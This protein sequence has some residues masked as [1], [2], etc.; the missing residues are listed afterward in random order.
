MAS[1]TYLYYVRRPIPSANVAV[2]PIP[3]WREDH[4]QP[5]ELAQRSRRS[6]LQVPS[7]AL[8]ECSGMNGYN[9]GLDVKP[10]NDG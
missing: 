4:F 2:N 9:W 1:G 7:E 6:P 10:V 3:Q 5:V 8:P